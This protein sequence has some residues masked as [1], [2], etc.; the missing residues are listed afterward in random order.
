MLEKIN[1]L[2]KIENFIYKMIIIFFQD[3]S[4]ITAFGVCRGFWGSCSPQ[5]YQYFDNNIDEHYVKYI[6]DDIATNDDDIATND[7]NVNTH[8]F[9][10]SEHCSD[11]YNIATIVYP[12]SILI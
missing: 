12:F 7:D 1:K 8:I 6:D 9:A 11:M 2:T 4:I 10:R 3:G 5:R